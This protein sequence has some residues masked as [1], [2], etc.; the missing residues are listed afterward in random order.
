VAGSRQTRGG[1]AGSRQTRGGVAGSR[2]TRGG[3]A[4]AG[5]AGAGEV[6]GGVAGWHRL[7]A[8]LTRD[9]P[10]VPE[11]FRHLVADL[12]A[13]PPVLPGWWRR[14]GAFLLTTVTA[15]MTE[16]PTELPGNALLAVA[17]PIESWRL[18]PLV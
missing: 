13:L 4:G 2:Q 7:T 11:R 6:G 1:V 9:L 14:E 15:A 16:P 3:E 12:A 8:R 5:E 17:E 10:A 18:N